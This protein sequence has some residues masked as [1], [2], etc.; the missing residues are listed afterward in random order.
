MAEVRI[1]LNFFVLFACLAHS[2]YDIHIA[3]SPGCFLVARSKILKIRAWPECFVLSLT[4]NR[5]HRFWRSCSRLI[6]HAA[7]RA[8]ST[9]WDPLARTL[10]SKLDLFL[11]RF[12][13]SS[14]KVPII[15]MLQKS[16]TNCLWMDT[17]LWISSSAQILAV[18]ALLVLGRTSLYHLDLTL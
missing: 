3:T 8:K 10:C 7:Y 16:W 12:L 13:I 4:R 2:K 5:L 6:S 17:P 9:G 18:E 14:C 11:T 1:A 15:R